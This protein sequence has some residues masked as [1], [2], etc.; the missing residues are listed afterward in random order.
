MLPGRRFCGLVS[1]E[2]FCSTFGLQ[3]APAL[4]LAGLWIVEVP[5]NAWLV[6]GQMHGLAVLDAMPV[7]AGRLAQVRV[8]RP[9][10]AV[11]GA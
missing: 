2:P 6:F 10:A 7:D 5:G 1:R 4:I 11:P 3:E 8:V 9:E